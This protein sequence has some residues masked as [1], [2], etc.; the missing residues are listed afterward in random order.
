LDD[1]APD[2]KRAKTETLS[3]RLDPKT[4]FIL[5]F[6]ARLQGQSITTIVERAI[7]DNAGKVGLGPRYDE[8]GNEMEPRTWTQYWD[9]S[10]GV[11]ILKLLADSE[12]PSN[13]DED[14]LRQF[15]LSH[16]KFFYSEQEGKQPR[17]AYVDILWPRIDYLLT[18][19]RDTRSENYWAVSSEMMLMLRS[20]NLAPPEDWPPRA[21]GS[22]KVTNAQT[23]NIKG[24]LDD[25]IPF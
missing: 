11:R 19:W 4:K 24:D 21:K 22:T 7:K 14:E 13:Y 17:R 12:Y 16:W 9:P 18:K 15:T 8:R 25:D 2:R 23:A 10:E 20:A 1:V 3:L 6:V 5:D